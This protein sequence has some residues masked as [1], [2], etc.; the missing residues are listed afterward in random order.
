MKQRPSVG[1]TLLELLIVMT[2]I[3]ILSTIAYPMY[4]QY[5]IRARRTEGQT[6]LIDLSARLERYYAAHNT[7]ASASIASGD[8]K[9]DVLSN[10]QS[11]KAW[12]RLSITAKTPR[13]YTLQATPLKA[14][15]VAD[16]ACACLTLNS[17]GEHGRSGT[18]PLERCW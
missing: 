1:I 9:H 14:Q 6:A 4:A 7:Y 5:L 8:P 3:G 12:Y 16:K 15:A 18:A 11:P 2:I 17:L 10:T 13:S